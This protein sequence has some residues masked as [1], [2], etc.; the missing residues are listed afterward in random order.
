MKA[1]LVL[2]FV[3][4][5]VFSLASVSSLSAQ[6]QQSSQTMSGAA[7]AAASSPAAASTAKSTAAKKNRPPVFRATKDQITQAVAMLRTRNLYSGADTTKLTAEVRTALKQFQTAEGMKATGTLN[8]ATLEKMSI[9]LTDNQK[10]MMSK[11]PKM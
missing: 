2:A 6:Q 10:A 1:N 8:A 3:C 5:C 7:A 4:A 9:T 11:M